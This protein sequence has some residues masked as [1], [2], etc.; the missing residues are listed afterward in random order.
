MSLRQSNQSGNDWGWLR[1]TD[2]NSSDDISVNG[3][4]SIDLEYSKPSFEIDRCISR[5]FS[6]INNR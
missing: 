5:T 3:V 1:D 4:S 2:S 6:S